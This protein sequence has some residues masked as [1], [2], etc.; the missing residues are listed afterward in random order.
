M[1]R[2]V[3]AAGLAALAGQQPG[4]YILYPWN[5]ATIADVRALTA[6]LS[7]VPASGSSMS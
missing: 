5:Y 6:T 1:G 4:G 2:Q 7:A 3:D